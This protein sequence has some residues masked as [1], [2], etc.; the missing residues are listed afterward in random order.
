M[1]GNMLTYMH[2]QVTTRGSF[3][4][5]ERELHQVRIT[6]ADG[7]QPPLSAM[8]V[9]TVQVIDENDNT[10]AFASPVYSVVFKEN[11][12]V[13]AVVI[14]LNATDEDAG[15]HARTVYS[16]K[17]V[18]NTPR[19]VMSI[20]SSTG[21]VRALVALDY[22]SG[23]RHFV[24]VVTA[25]DSGAAHRSSTTLLNVTL[26]DVNDEAPRFSNASYTFT[27]RENTSPPLEIGIIS[28][29]DADSSPFNRILYT[30]AA[31]S[32]LSADC[33]AIDRHSGLLITLKS[34]DREVLDLH[35]LIVT[36]SNG[37]DVIVTG[38]D[39]V[40]RDVISSSVTVTIRLTDENDNA[41][42]FVFPSRYNSTVHVADSATVGSVAAM[43][44][45]NDPDLNSK[46]TLDMTGGDK[47]GLFNLDPSRG[48][49]LVAKPLNGYADLEFEIL[50]SAV[51]N[52]QPPLRSSEALYVRIVHAPPPPTLDLGR[53][54]GARAASLLRG[55]SISIV[56]AVAGGLLLVFTCVLIVVCIRCCRSRQL[57]K[58]QKSRELRVATNGKGSS[59]LQRIDGGG[60]G[61]E[62]T[63]MLYRNQGRQLLQQQQGCQ[64]YVDRASAE[65]MAV[66]RGLGEDIIRSNSKDRDRATSPAAQRLLGISSAGDGSHRA[67]TVR[68][69][70]ADGASGDEDEDDRASPVRLHCS[71]QHTIVSLL[72]IL[73]FCS[74][75]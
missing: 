40:E 5:E 75:A 21:A 64:W 53:A 54:L 47:N 62:T 9:L 27:I 22:E 44:L 7:G 15:A 31:R 1:T 69:R 46:V 38:D 4:R 3:D 36:A 6:C 35:E 45:V 11:N 73:S 66:C 55:D 61:E 34:L 58:R 48:V 32:P 70:D 30:L 37:N 72:L 52:G 20:D 19:R 65:D 60:E 26:T 50:L 42:V 25:T 68:W 18:S 59:S 2:V 16:M 29:T 63:C 28:A 74:F 41:P 17:E 49:L 13:G 43:L 39:I 67:L 14:K 71:P 57:S 51:D 10:P 12:S 33:F 56:I 8:R 23:V 24:Y